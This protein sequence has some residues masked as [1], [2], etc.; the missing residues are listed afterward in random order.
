MTRVSNLTAAVLIG[1]AGALPARAAEPVV[2][3]IAIRGIEAAVLRFT[4]SDSGGGYSVTGRLDSAG[5]LGLLR[6]VRYDA[7]A[8]GA[9]KGKRFTPA[10]YSEKAD[11]GRRKS[12]AVMEYR[13][14]VP[15]VK[16]YNPPR[17][18]GPDTI[19]PATQ[20]GTVDPLTAIYAV[21]R[22]VPAGSECNLKLV[23]FDGKRRSQVVLGPPTTAKAGVTCAGEYRRLAGYSAEDMAERSRFAFTI[24]L[25]PAAG[26]LMQVT[27]VRTETLY[28]RAVMT[29]R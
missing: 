25:K 17:L 9:V 27:E 4:G 20:G 19:D 1:L 8:R 7:T 2:F 15:Q 24:A 22:D 6:T 21:L 26:G 29:R 13:R 10:S 3:D 18:P 12:E 11:T 28:G 14:G 5:L 23:L 16:S